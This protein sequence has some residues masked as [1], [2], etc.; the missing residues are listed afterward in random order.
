MGRRR[1]RPREDHRPDLWLHPEGGHAQDGRH[2]RRRSLQGAG[3]LSRSPLGCTFYP[4]SCLCAFV[5]GYG[6]RRARFKKRLSRIASSI[7]ALPPA[8][9]S[10]VK[11]TLSSSLRLA[12]TSR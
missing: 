7:C 10:H 8:I 6:R 12:P 11:S 9:G 1:A 5:R 2:P 4:T 3:N